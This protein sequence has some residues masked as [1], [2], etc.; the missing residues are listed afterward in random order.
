ML[1]TQPG[2]FHLD[3]Q[4]LPDL[5]V[6]DLADGDRR[7]PGT[8]QCV[9]VMGDDMELAVIPPIRAWRMDMCPTGMTIYREVSIMTMPSRPDKYRTNLEVSARL[10]SQPRI[11][12]CWCASASSAPDTR[13]ITSNPTPSRNI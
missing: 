13:V 12:I 9:D 5:I 8:E 7:E 1:H 10:K 6:A 4:P 2:L 3:E 11:M